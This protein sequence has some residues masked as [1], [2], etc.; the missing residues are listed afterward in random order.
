MKTLITARFDRDYMESLRAFASEIDFDGFGVNGV[1]ME[2][3]DL[4]KALKGKELLISEI[5]DITREVI[6]K[7]D[8]LK[9]IVCCRNE[10]FAS[11]DV[12]AA[13]EKG[14]PV[15]YAKGRNAIAV[16][17]HTIALLMCVSKNIALTDYLLKHTNELT[18]CNYSDKKGERKD[19]VSEWSMDPKAPF[20][21]YGGKPEMYGKIFGQIGFGCIGKEVAKRALCF[22]MDLL[23]YDPYLKKEDVE[24]YGRLV[25]LETLMRES[26]FISI[27]C[28]VTPETEGMISRDMINMMK[29][30]SYLLNT[31]RAA[32]V[33]Y[34]ALYDA[35]SNNRIAGAGLD[36]F[37]VEPIPMNDKFLEL[38]NT[39]L[40]PHLAGSSKDII[41]HQTEI[42]LD[43][44]KKLLAGEKPEFISNSQVL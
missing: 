20:A 3:D 22:G 33:D 16:A 29:P 11:V 12:E 10:P 19:I 5:E 17:E 21:V 6:E 42:V 1:K 43:Q 32:I 28:N 13:T 37:P 8:S 14:I 41:S 38:K 39:V 9:I 30:T 4:I 23:I 18:N 15:L 34:D 27:S 25:S 7:S 44:L 35:L 24:N 36:V 31:A 40:T 2:T 26:D